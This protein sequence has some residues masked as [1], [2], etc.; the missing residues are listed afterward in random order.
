MKTNKNKYWYAIYTKSRCEKKINTALI[1]KGIETYLPLKKEYRQ[2]SDRKKL[3]ESPF[4]PSY[5]FV[6]LS[7]NE[8]V[9]VLQTD[10]V[11]KMITFLG[12]AA[13]IPDAQIDTLKLLID[14]ENDFTIITTPLQRGD[15]VEIKS[16]S[17]AG[18]T[19]E[20]H[21]IYSKSKI[22]VRIDNIGYSLLIDTNNHILHK[23]K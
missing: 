14:S 19:G 10:G 6:R 17:L 9:N 20:I 23:V 3:I 8:R 21:D 13:I 1:N 16:G 4:I 12:Q 5:I 22:L 18:I 2:W 7:S 11:V 15:Y